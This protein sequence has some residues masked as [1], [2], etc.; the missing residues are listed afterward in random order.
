MKSVVLMSLLM[1]SASATAGVI[2]Y[3]F[4]T[5]TYGGFYATTLLSKNPI[6]IFKG[7][8]QTT[9]IVR[10]AA[11]YWAAWGVVRE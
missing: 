8:L 5:Q 1:M 2:R 3:D 10:A 4:N 7:F 6:K 11:F 9:T